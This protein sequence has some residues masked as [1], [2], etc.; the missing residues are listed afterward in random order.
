MTARAMNHEG[1][2][3]DGKPILP[4]NTFLT[5]SGRTTTPYP[6][7]SLKS[8]RTC[9]LAEKNAN[10]WLIDNAVTEAKAR[11]DW[12]NANAFT[13]EIPKNLPPSSIASMLEYL[14]GEQPEL[15]KPFLKPLMARK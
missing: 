5:S 10:Q 13:R 1:K 6:N 15:P 4:G 8:S 7:Y 14:F 9:T 12:F 2:P 3:L 11:Q